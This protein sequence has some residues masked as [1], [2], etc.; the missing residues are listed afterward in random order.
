MKRLR[1]SEGNRK[2]LRW[3][4]IASIVS[5]TVLNGCNS[6]QSNSP[7]QSQ[8]TAVQAVVVAAKR[9]PVSEILPL[10]GTILANEMV[11]IKPETDGIIQEIHY[12]A[13]QKVDKGHLLVLL[14]DSKLAALLAETEANFRLS[15]ATHERSK[16]LLKENLISQQEFDQVT[17]TYAVNQASLE[18]KRRQLRDTRVLAPFAGVMGARQISPGQV[19]NRTTTL[20]SLVDLDTV[21]V[22][23]EIPERYLSQIAIGQKLTFTVAA[24]PTNDFPG[25]VFFIAP[26]LSET[27]RTASVQARIANPEHKLRP[28]MFASLTLT[29]IVRESAI[30]IPDPAIINNGNLSMVFTVA[31]DDTANLRPIKVGERLAGKAEVV[32]GL[33]EGVDVV[34]EGH[35]KIAPGSKIKRSNPEKAAIYQN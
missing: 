25:Q 10:I 22:E 4:I 3:L 18:L 33:A 9:E 6:K 24:Y 34:V 23:V 13:G 21:K 1:S 2:N 35:Q 5:L 31:K 8:S 11:D 28:G 17:A 29:L 32:E 15:L 20:G 30:V 26:Q 12:E 14:D 27:L 16:Q 7:T 19:V